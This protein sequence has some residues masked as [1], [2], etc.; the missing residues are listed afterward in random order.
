MSH[1]PRHD[2]PEY[3]PQIGGGSALSGYEPLLGGLR[4]APLDADR[5]ARLLQVRSDSERR[6]LLL[7]VAD[8]GL[9]AQYARELA[10]AMLPGARHRVG[11][12]HGTFTQGQRVA[13]IEALAHIGSYESILPLLE[14][15]ADSTFVIR[16]SA[17]Q[18]LMRVIGRLDPAD[19]R[20]ALAYRA[21]VDALRILPLGGRKLVADLL[22]RAPVELVIGPLLIRG[23]SAPEWG[24][25]CDSALVLGRLGDKR[26][27]R[28]LLDTLADPSSAVRAACAW[29]LGRFDAP[30]VLSALAD[31]SR[32]DPDEAVRGAAVEA[33]GQHAQRRWNQ[34]QALEPAIE[35]ILE[36]LKH[37]D[38]VRQAALD[39]LAEIDAP[40]A[41]QAL[42]KLGI[43]P[44]RGQR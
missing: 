37:R 40:A 43:R 14:G 19:R 10:E 12:W 2:A 30:P 32:S 25:R 3:S 34:Q 11:D 26:A 41:R 8:Y 35:P 5:I 1:S 23:L 20:T 7:Q 9:T 33:L 22:A 15:V 13:A 36:A 42:E 44:G 38:S 18:A 27:V 17:G 31:C 39:A 6:L 16:S 21:L 29:S 24:A 28:R 4:R